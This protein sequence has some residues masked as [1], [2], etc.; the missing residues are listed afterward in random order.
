MH[1]G[2]AALRELIP[3]VKTTKV[4]RGYWMRLQKEITKDS[5]KLQSAQPGDTKCPVYKLFHNIS[6]STD[7]PA[8]EMLASIQ[9]FAT[10][11]TFLDADLTLIV[12]EGRFTDMK[13]R[14][15][16]DYCDVAR[17]FPAD[18]AVLAHFLSRVVRSFIMTWYSPDENELV[19]HQMWNLTTKLRNLGERLLSG[20]EDSAQAMGTMLTEVGNM[21][22]KCFLKEMS[23]LLGLLDMKHGLAKSE[24]GK[25]VMCRTEMSHAQTMLDEY[26]GLCSMAKGV[27]NLAISYKTKVAM[28][29]A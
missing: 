18:D 22:G 13:V 8:S 7:L 17:I 2:P 5:R 23:T 19:N 24:Q 29:E 25:A 3:V 10:H 14:L 28:L 1:D 27:R 21:A 9:H 16:N 6:L 20:G 11:N 26:M 4:E 12:K 15:Y